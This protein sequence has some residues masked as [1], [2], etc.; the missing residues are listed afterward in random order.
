MM[1]RSSS[2]FPSEPDTPS[3]P[4]EEEADEHEEETHAQ[5]EA[6]QVEPEQAA[7]QHVE[8]HQIQAADPE[9]PIQSEPPLQQTDPHTLIQ[10]A[11]P[12]ATTATPAAHPSDDDTSS[13]P[14]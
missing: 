4:S 9:I 14:A 6:E 11:D 7:P 12:Q 10:F 3:E 5:R 1:I 8:P 13:H 2:D